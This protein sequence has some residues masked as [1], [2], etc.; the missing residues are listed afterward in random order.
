MNTD[1]LINII[2][3]EV[4]KRITMLSSENL[5]ERS[6]RILILDSIANKN[7]YNHGEVISKYSDTKFLDDYS[8][9]EGVDSFDYIIAPELS[10]NDLVSIAIGVSESEISKIIIDAILKGKK[11]IVLEEGMYYKKFKDTANKNFFSMLKGYEEKIISFG[12]EIVRKEELADCLDEEKIKVST[13]TLNKELDQNQAKEIMITKRVICE[14]EIEQLW[15]KG[16]RTI[17]VDKKSII[18]PLAKDF[19]RNYEINI[20]F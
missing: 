6:K 15:K 5:K 14:R 17:V 8:N 7:K 2:T 10:N 12:I 9:K 13:E 4:L 16:Y 3:E 19:I 20:K 11:V 1:S 18:T